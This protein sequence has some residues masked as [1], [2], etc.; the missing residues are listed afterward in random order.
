MTTSAGTKSSNKIFVT[1]RGY[2]EQL[3]LQ[4]KGITQQQQLGATTIA[5][6][7]EA[8]KSRLKS[9]VQPRIA[10]ESQSKYVDYHWE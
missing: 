3:L 2:E 7:E 10:L 9:Q 6:L 1:Q 8:K 4:P 5:L